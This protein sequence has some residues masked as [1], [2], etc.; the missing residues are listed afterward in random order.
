MA[1]PEGFRCGGQVYGEGGHQR[2]LWSGGR[3]GADLEAEWTRGR[4]RGG[5]RRHRAWRGEHEEW[6]SGGGGRRWREESW[7]W[8]PWWRRVPLSWSWR[9]GHGPRSG[10]DKHWWPPGHWRWCRGSSG[11]LRW[12]RWPPGHWR[13]WWSPG[14]LGRGGTGAQREE[15]LVTS[16]CGGREAL[17]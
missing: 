14:H 12:S 13:S 3:G 11:H 5:R 15:L 16:W 17:R 2:P 4:R 1:E 7:V 10:E 8:V 9:W 6:L